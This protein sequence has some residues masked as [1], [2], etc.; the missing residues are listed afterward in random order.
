[1]VLECV[2]IVSD[3]VNWLATLVEADFSHAF[4]LACQRVGVVLMFVD[5]NNDG[6]H[7]V[8]EQ[9]IRSVVLAL[10][11]VS[12]LNLTIPCE[13]WYVAALSSFVQQSGD[14][15]LFE[16]R[17]FVGLGLACGTKIAYAINLG[18]TATGT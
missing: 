9:E 12:V 13:I 2:G 8:F 5:L 16:P 11:W 18:Q 7:I 14:L 17:I 10:Y 1:M 3:P 6:T 4:E 15:H